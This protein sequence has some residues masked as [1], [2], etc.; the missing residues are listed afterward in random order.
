MT[1]LT[2]TINGFRSLISLD[3]KPRSTRLSIATQPF[4][5][6][7]HQPVATLTID[8]DEKKNISFKNELRLSSSTFE[9]VQAVTF[10]SAAQA[11]SSQVTQWEALSRSMLDA[12]DA[13][14]YLTELAVQQDWEAL[15]IA[16]TLLPDPL[17]ELTTRCNY[18]Y[19]VNKASNIAAAL[20]R[21]PSFGAVNGLYSRYM[22][23]P[24]VKTDDFSSEGKMMLNVMSLL[25]NRFTTTSNWDHE[26]GQISFLLLERDDV[27]H[28][29]R[30]LTSSEPVFSMKEGLLIS[31]G[32][33]QSLPP[34]KLLEH[35]LSTRPKMES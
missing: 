20:I 31:G 29:A 13:A 21:H 24:N 5:S 9:G 33:E 35:L 32:G 15:A 18:N 2:R 30:S 17:A 26:G 11:A 25:L 23:S 3:T 1:T 16:I 19:R 4:S 6:R 34:E 12:S 28:Y 14:Y 10:L 8:K 7:F 27:P 22:Q